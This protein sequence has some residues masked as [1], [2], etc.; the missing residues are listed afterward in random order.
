MVRWWWPGLDVERDELLAEIRDMDE[1][2]FAGAE[3]QTFM[4]GAPSDLAKHDRARFD[5][6]HRFMQPYYYQMV[7][8]VLDEAA[9]RGMTIDLTICSAWPAGGTHITPENMLKTLGMGAKIVRG[10]KLFRGALPRCAKPLVAYIPKQVPLLGA[11]AS[12]NPGQ[13][14]PLR[15]LAA[16]PLGRPGRVR[17]WRTKTSELDISTLRD[18]TA[19]MDAQGRLQWQVP[20]GTWQIIAVYAGPSGTHPLFDARQQPDAISHVLDHLASDPIR[21]HLDAHL[22]R[23]REYF[24]RHFG[25]TLRAFFTDSL[26]LAAE[27]AWT[28]NLLAEFER[29]RGYDITPYLACCYVPGR[30]NKYISMVVR[31][32]KPCFDFADDLGERIRYDYERTVSD[33]FAERFV[34]TMTEWADANGLQSRIQA[35]GIRADT[36]RA[37]GI[38]HIPETEQLFAGGP[39]D[40]LKLAGSAAAIY[41]KPLVTSESLVWMGRDYLTTPLKLKVAADRLFVSGINQLIL[42]G[43]PYQ[44]PAFGYPGFQPF[45]SPHMPMINFASNMSAASPFRAFFPAINGYVTRAQYLMSSGPATPNVGIYY[46]LL[47]YPDTTLR[48]EELM[49]GRLDD[50]DAEPAKGLLSSKPP[51]H[52]DGDE[53][54][55]AQ[56]AQLGDRLMAGGYNYVHINEER[57]LQAQLAGRI[58]KVGA[59]EL[60][61]LILL[62]IERLSVALAYKLAELSEQGFPVMV[63]GRVPHKQPGFHDW[64][65]GDQ[66]VAAC[67]ARIVAGSQVGVLP[68]DKVVPQF[69]SL[70]IAPG[71]RF[72]SPQAYIQYI[73]R[74][75]ESCRTFFVRNASREPTSVPVVFPGETAIPLRYDLWTGKVSQWE[76]Y[77]NTDD[78][79]ALDLDLG[80]Y[81]SQA[82]VFDDRVEP[83]PHLVAANAQIERVADELVARG[84]DSGEYAF[85]HSDGRTV[86][87]SIQQPA[88]EVSLT[89]W[90]L[91]SDVRLVDGTSQRLDLDLDDLQDWRRLEPFKHCSS[92]GDYATRFVLEEKH[93]APGHRLLLDLGRVCDTAE[94]MLND[95]WLTPAL[96]AMPFQ[97]PITSAAKLGENEL[98]IRVTPTLRNRLVGYAAEGHKE[99]KRFKHKSLAPSGLLGPVRVVTEWERTLWSVE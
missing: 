3:I 88:S 93:L 33:L 9:T 6:A 2:G 45:S 11:V 89:S 79:M 76:V 39:L 19:F 99:Y 85:T 47:N 78:G 48:A 77:Q 81:G 64:Q 31:G 82:I 57:L 67:A 92:P 46:P 7:Q 36:L 28:D 22:G 8:A 18:I 98:L 1:A 38:A 41:D 70:G 30:D 73:R 55:V 4:I 61:A 87:I 20:E 44:H 53:A 29:R 50:L 14:E 90:H 74:R 94:V 23:G 75:S 40:F 84:V 27:W 10:P 68:V 34:G 52:L 26:E 16:K 56:Q 80:A 51:K 71:L 58:L 91:R 59:V 32:S 43:Y 37:Y 49:G 86:N 65:V 96:L 66:T 12:W 42:H 21:N 35:Y 15:V 72:A 5:R 17:T 83:L 69:Q 13:L 60:D 97:I 25:Q 54:W 63:V 62:D 24:A 95:Q